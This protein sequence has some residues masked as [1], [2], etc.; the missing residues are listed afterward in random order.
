MDIAFSDDKFWQCEAIPPPPADFPAASKAS[1]AKK[2]QDCGGAKSSTGFY[3][4]VTIGTAG[5]A[6]G[7]KAVVQHMVVA[8]IM[9][10]PGKT[11]GDTIVPITVNL[12]E[13]FKEYPAID[14]HKQHICCEDIIDVTVEAN[15]ALINLPAG[16]AAIAAGEHAGPILP[17]DPTDKTPQ[18][19][20]D[21]V[22][23]NY[24][25]AWGYRYEY[26]GCHPAKPETSC[27]KSKCLKAWSRTRSYDAQQGTWT[28]SPKTTKD[29]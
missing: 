3:M 28:E 22:R 25:L 23:D 4:K 27:G 18:Q 21:T 12:M 29:F 14:W 9:K 7:G 17:K 2:E 1:L 13:Y 11:C 15:A 5:G 6:A 19:V 8:G 20:H 16:V 26:D 10:R 24:T